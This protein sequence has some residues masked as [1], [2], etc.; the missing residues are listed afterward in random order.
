[1]DHPKAVG[2]RS[3]LAIMLALQAAGNQRPIQTKHER[4]AGQLVKVVSYSLDQSHVVG[5]DR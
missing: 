1:M 3:T 5:C 4:V 2:D